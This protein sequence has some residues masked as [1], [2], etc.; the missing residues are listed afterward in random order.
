MIRASVG[1]VPLVYEP[2][3][4]RVLDQSRLP[5]EQDWLDLREPAS[6]IEAITSLRVRGAPLIGVAGAYAVALA[7]RTVPLDMFP[8]AA[9][10]I[11]EARPTAV[12]LA[13]SVDRVLRRIDGLAGRPGAVEAAEDEARTVHAEEA[14]A[15]ESIGR[16]GAE[17]IPE[18]AG[19]LTYCNTGALATGGIGTALGVIRT[20]FEAGRVR[21]VWVPETRP[22]LQGSR[23]TAWELGRLGIPHSILT[24]GATGSVLASGWVQAVVVGADRIAANGDFANKV[25]TYVMAVLAARH[26]VPFFVAAPLTTVDP[27]AP[28]GASIAIEDRPASELRFAG[29]TVVAPGDSPV[30]NPAFDVTP[31]ELVSAI[32]TDR[33]VHLPPYDLRG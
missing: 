20:A 12:N 4:L 11:R 29:S 7:L 33:R 23:L 24:E 19:V 5:S 21:E 6:V 18:G 17:L 27:Q 13:R 1:I 3:V 16:L 25:G 9:G 2:G 30:L 15:C 10:A 28:D 31:A 26:D 8:A 14:A 32:V 22:L